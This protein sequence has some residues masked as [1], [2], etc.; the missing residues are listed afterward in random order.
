MYKLKSSKSIS[1]RF[2]LSAS[3]K[4]M[5]YPAGHNHLLQKKKSKSKRQLRKISQISTYEYKVI[6][7]KISKYF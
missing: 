3:G 4:L 7:S 6:K 2:K 1:K 5:R